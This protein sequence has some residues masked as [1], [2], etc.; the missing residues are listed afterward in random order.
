MTGLSEQ[1]LD[2]RRRAREFTDDLI[3]WEVEIEMANGHVGRPLAEK[4]HRAALDSGMYASNM[5]ASLGGPG[6]TSLQQVLVQEQVGRVTNG[7]AWCLHTPPQWWVEVAT[8]EQRERWLLPAVRGERHECYAITEEY[9]GTDVSDLATT[10]R[11]DGDEYVVSGTKWHVTSYNLA[12]YCFVQAVLSDG[13]HA[14]EHVL[15]VVDLPDAG[16]RVER[17]PKYM[18]HIADEHPIVVFDNV[19]IPASQLIGQE[20]QGM[21][22]TQD[23]FRFERVMVA[24]RCV[25]AASRLLDEMTTFAGERIVGGQRLGDYQLVTAMLADS[26]DRAVRR[27]G[28]ALRDGARY[29]RRRG[30]QG[31]PRPRVDGQA[32]VLRDGRPR[33]RPGCA[34]LRWPWL[35]ARER[36]RADVPRAARRAD[37]GGRVGDPARHRRAAAAQARHCCGARRGVVRLEV[38]STS[39]PAWQ[40]SRGW[41]DARAA[42]SMSDDRAGETAEALLRGLLVGVLL[43][44]TVMG[45]LWAVQRQLIYFP[46]AARVPPAGEVIAGARDVSLHTEDGL[47]LGAWFVPAAGG[48][49]PGTPMAVLVAPGNGGNR[50]G[51]AGLAEELSARGLAVLLMDYRGYGGNPGSPTEE[52]LAADAFAATEALEALGYPPERTIYFGE[53]LGTGVVAASRCGARQPEWC[54]ARPS[55]SWPTSGRTTTHS[56]RC[57]SCFGIGSRSSSI[58]RRAKC[59]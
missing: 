34:G 49:T 18:H 3:P 9:A 8:D 16:I 58:C 51:R 35:H 15:L 53:S 5:P 4:L 54:C 43:I 26:A 23:W 14:G 31:P 52:G 47:E 19:R 55:P 57:G 30:P 12:D 44:G 40:A 7:L 37:L 10:A 11:R 32:A 13:E 48:A 24:A 29:R 33:R 20:G 22:F 41:Q 28:R 6:F 36:R 50:K 17:T 27:P 1:D 21:T 46:D 25:G 2:I 38:T 59:R 56:C 45:I 42:A 39:V